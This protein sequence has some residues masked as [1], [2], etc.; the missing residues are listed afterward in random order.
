M[1]TEPPDSPLCAQVQTDGNSSSVI[2]SRG[3]TDEFA[4]PPDPST[5]TVD[6]GIIPEGQVAVSLSERKIKVEDL[7]RSDFPNLATEARHLLLEFPDCIYLKDI[8]CTGIKTLQ[9]RIMFNGPVFFH[10]QYKIPKILDE[11]VTQEISRLLRA[12]VLEPT[13]SQYSNSII[14]IVKPNGKIRLALDIRYLNAHTPIDKVYLGDLQEILNELDNMSVFT[15]LDCAMGFHQMELYPESKKFT[16]FRWKNNAYQYR[17][18]L[19]GLSSAPAA[20][21]RQMAVTLSGIQNVAYYLDDI[22]IYSRNISQHLATLRHVFQRL[23]HH[24]LELNLS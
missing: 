21:S 9:H 4:E 1:V 15:T 10:R 20:W 12:G 17:Y 23:R 18:L 19:F 24:G 8:P 6:S 3:N 5:V 16:A 2:D 14:P 22:I 7:I 11:S 13:D